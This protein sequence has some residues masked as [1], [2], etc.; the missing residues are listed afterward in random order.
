MRQLLGKDSVLQNERLNGHKAMCPAIASTIYGVNQDSWNESAYATLAAAWRVSASL[1][2]HAAI[3]S[4]ARDLWKLDRMLKD[5]L[6][7]IYKAVENPPKVPEPV[8]PDQVMAMA[9]ALQKI[10]A[11]ID[12]NYTR[13]RNG[14]LTNHSIL[15]IVFNSVKVRSEEIL[16]IGDWLASYSDPDADRLLDRAIDELHRGEVH[17][18]AVLN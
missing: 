14:G 3:L 2:R 11:T 10:H 4:L 17:D 16:D 6:E 12:S 15:G 18:L 8:T 13:A 7:R 5:F 1:K 9:D